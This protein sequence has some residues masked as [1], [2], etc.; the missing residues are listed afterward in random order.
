[1]EHGHHHDHHH[2]H[3]H[4]HHHAHEIKSLNG[5]Y[6]LS[7]I[8]NLGFV[9]IE[10]GIGIWKNSVGLVS[11]A[12]H[13]LSDVF[14]LLLAL[15]AFK[16]A[17]SQSTKRFTYGYKKASVLISLVNALILLVAIGAIYLES[18]HKFFTPVAIDGSAISWTAGIG[19][20]INGFTAFLLMKQQGHD[21]NTRGAFLHMATDTLVSAGV[22]VS[23][24]VITYTGWYVIDPIIGILIATVILVGTFNLLRESLNMTIDA[25]PESIDI[26]D[27]HEVIESTEGVKDVHHIHIWPIST[28]LNALTAHII[29]EDLMDGPRITE[30]IRHRL[31]EKGISHSTIQVEDKTCE[32]HDHNCHAE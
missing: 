7:I 8:L 25:V 30:E 31:Q 27:I 10:A 4:E 18:F 12:G 24:I 29:V 32:C 11:D 6:I 15:F 21:I 17:K 5:V 14:S 23:G 1:M 22:L 19:I 16:L 2:E 9:I 3:H 13:N 20:L 28:T 26:D